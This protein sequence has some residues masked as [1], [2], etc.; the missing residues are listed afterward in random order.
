MPDMLCRPYAAQ[1][2]DVGVQQ[3]RQVRARDAVPGAGRARQVRVPAGD[4]VGGG[5]LVALAGT[6]EPTAPGAAS[7]QPSDMPLARAMS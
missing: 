1:R 2:F 4:E 6:E 7:G 3:Q 5:V